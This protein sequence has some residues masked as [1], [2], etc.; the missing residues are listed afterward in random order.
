MNKEMLL[1]VQTILSMLEKIEYP[2][3]TIL[4]PFDN[5]SHHNL[6]KP[7]VE[8]IQLIVRENAT[9]LQEIQ[10]VI[11][12]EKGNVKNEFLPCVKPFNAKIK[13]QNAFVKRQRKEFDLDALQRKAREA[14][15]SP[16]KLLQKSLEELTQLKEEATIKEWLKKEI[17][18]EDGKVIFEVNGVRKTS[19]EESKSKRNYDVNFDECETF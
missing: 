18:K 8:K 15:T 11:A 13:E 17:A 2:K 1:D 7:T 5:D 19:I 3:K 12:D 16:T 10:R 14:N 4:V 9:K 6:H